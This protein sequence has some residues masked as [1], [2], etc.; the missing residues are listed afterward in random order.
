VRW[1]QLGA[2]SPLMRAHGLRPR[3]PWAF[4]EQALDICRDWVR[5]RYSLLPYLW[6][7]ARES[8]SNGW[9]VLRP[10]GLHHPDDR[11]ARSIDDSFLLGRDL[12]VVPVFDD[13]AA[14]VQRT[15]Y[16]PE[17][18]WFDLH[19]DTRYEGPGFHTVEVPLERM[20][21]LV[22]GGAVIPRVEVDETVRSVEDL[23]G[24]PWTRHAYGDVVGSGPELVGF[25][26][27]PAVV[28]DEVVRHG[29]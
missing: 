23:H 21:V 13:G 24:R 17:G 14:P 26:S 4:G 2:L 7:V 19:D 9:P 8:A 27:R 1:T 10:L 12:L 3:E 6:Q 25:D 11:V 15:F 22:R 18:E 5:L 28:A 16:V 29:S 20:P